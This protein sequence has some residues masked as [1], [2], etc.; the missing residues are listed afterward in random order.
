[1][2]NRIF[3]FEVLHLTNYVLSWA[4]WNW[5]NVYRVGGQLTSIINAASSEILS[6]RSL[7]LVGK[8]NKWEE[9]SISFLGNTCVVHL[10]TWVMHTCDENCKLCRNIWSGNITGSM[11]ESS[12]VCLDPCLYVSFFLFEA[13]SFSVCPGSPHIHSGLTAS[14][15][16]VFKLQGSHHAQHTLGLILGK[17]H[18]VNIPIGKSLMRL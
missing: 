17:S 1:M 3:G 18:I 9:G 4:I 16:H 11:M 6:T 8:K 10:I 2:T 15:S 13:R 14:T 12:C 7:Y 5:L